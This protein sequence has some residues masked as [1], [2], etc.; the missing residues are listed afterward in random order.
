MK[1]RDACC[2]SVHGVSEPD[3][4][5]GLNNNVIELLKI[6]G[7]NEIKSVRHSPPGSLEEPSGT[8]SFR[9]PRPHPKTTAECLVTF[10]EDKLAILPLIGSVDGCGQAPPELADGHGVPIH[11]LVFPH[12]PEP[13]LLGGSS[14]SL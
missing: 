5:E 4:V 7:L 8:C 3:M 6:V 10:E 14:F 9:E 1:D 13:T 2:A 11:H 12:A